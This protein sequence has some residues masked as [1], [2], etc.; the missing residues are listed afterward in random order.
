MHSSKMKAV[1]QDRPLKE[2]GDPMERHPMKKPSR[3]R[4]RKDMLLTQKAGSR[5]EGPSQR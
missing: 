1:K 5:E 2:A 4:D 3:D